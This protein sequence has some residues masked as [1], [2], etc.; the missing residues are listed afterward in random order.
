MVGGPVSELIGE[1]QVIYGTSLTAEDLAPLVH[2]HLTRNE[3]LG[4]ALPAMMGKP[5]HAH[6]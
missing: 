4:E 2:A 3:A 1:A 5:L 6:G